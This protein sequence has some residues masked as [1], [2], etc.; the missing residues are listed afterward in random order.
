[1]IIIPPPLRPRPPRRRTTEDA[2]PSMLPFSLIWARYEPDGPG[3]AAIHLRF[4]RAINVAWLMNGQFGVYDGPNGNQLSGSGTQTLLGPM[5]VQ[6]PV[7]IIG[8]NHGTGTLL[9]AGAG[10]GIEAVDEGG[11]W[12]GVTWLAL[13]FG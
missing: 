5:E 9:Y 10:N 1:M 2:L 6:L 3:G 13:P 11:K 12:C 8:R 7:R 4:D